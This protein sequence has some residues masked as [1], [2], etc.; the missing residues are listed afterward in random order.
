MD[1]LSKL[2]EYNRILADKKPDIS[3]KLDQIAADIDY[4]AMMCD[5]DLEAEE[6][7]HDEV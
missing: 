1:N 6:N 4:I 5:I 3:A 2:L 7:D